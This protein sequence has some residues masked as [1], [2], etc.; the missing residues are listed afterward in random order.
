MKKTYKAPAVSVHK[1]LIESEILGQSRFRRTDY[2]NHRNAVDPFGLDPSQGCDESY[3][4]DLVEGE[5]WET[6]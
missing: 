2:G 3:S 4:I 5:G 6:L 1:L